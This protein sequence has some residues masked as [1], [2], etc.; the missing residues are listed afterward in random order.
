M[1]LRL[2]SI[3]VPL[4]GQSAR[5]TSEV[6]KAML[7]WQALPQD[8]AVE[9]FAWL[10]LAELTACKL[11]S[12]SSVLLN[13]IYVLSAAARSSTFHRKN[14]PKQRGAAKHPSLTLAGI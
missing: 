12:G 8:L 7:F 11:R 14:S 10:L 2:Q 5:V 4:R 9:I 6:H 13:D 1:L 3:S